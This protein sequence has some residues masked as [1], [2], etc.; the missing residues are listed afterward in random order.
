MRVMF[1]HSNGSIGTVDSQPKDNGGAYVVW[2]YGK[3]ANNEYITS[4]I[5]FSDYSQ[6]IEISEENYQAY[7]NCRAWSD[8]QKA[9]RATILGT[10][11]LQE[12]KKC[13]ECAHWAADPDDEYCAHP[14]ATEISVFGINLNRGRGN[15]SHKPSKPEDDPAFGICGP[16]GRLWEKRPE[17]RKLRRLL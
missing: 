16:E 3:D 4:T 5:R 2:N 8:E 6:L 10:A 17:S 14:K 1:K 9:V 13:R 7:V 12:S 15:I 11:E